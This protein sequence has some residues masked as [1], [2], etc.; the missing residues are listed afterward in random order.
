MPKSSQIIT[1]HKMGRRDKNCKACKHKDICTLSGGDFTHCPKMDMIPGNGTEKL[2][3]FEWE[4][5]QVFSF[6]QN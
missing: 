4:M 3:F 6:N 2:F 1:M 5:E